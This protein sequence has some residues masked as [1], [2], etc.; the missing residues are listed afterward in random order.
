MLNST[1]YEFLGNLDAD[2][3]FEPSY[4]ECI[5]QGFRE[6]PK[7]GIAGGI[8]FEPFHG[9]WI[10]QRTS[11]SW[12]VSGPIQMFRRHCYEDIGGFLPLK[13]GG[14]DAVAEVMARM[15]GWKVKAFSHIPVRHHRGTGT[16]T[17]SILCAKFR[18]GRMEHKIGYHPLFEIA[19]CCLRVLEVPYLI[20]G[21]SELCGYCWDFLNT[22]HREVP[23]NVVRF[24]RQE[25][26][27]RI[28]TIFTKEKR[29]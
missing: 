21:F 24:L 11:I 17:G 18:R 9:K 27:Q 29:R 14:E 20:G 13:D 15:R 25:Q 10:A 23:T 3:S 2:I 7:L 28:Y 8:L 19:K 4:Y 26:I 16:A 12:S 1:K 22:D 5:L 6:D